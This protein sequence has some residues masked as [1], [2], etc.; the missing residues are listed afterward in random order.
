M[1]METYR[2][3]ES[4]GKQ[5][6]L[7]CYEGNA[8]MDMLMHWKKGLQRDTRA[9]KIMP[10]AAVDATKSEQRVDTHTYRHPI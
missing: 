1:A 3:G 6:S 2:D 10:Q 7:V 8:G 4:H 5:Y 9:K